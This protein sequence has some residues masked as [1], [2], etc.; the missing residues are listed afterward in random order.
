MAKASKINIAEE[1]V[2]G[3]KFRGASSEISKCKFKLESFAMMIL[4][5]LLWKL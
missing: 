4:R 2:V 1:L 3:A 5:C